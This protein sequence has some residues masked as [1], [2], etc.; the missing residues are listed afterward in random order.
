MSLAREIAQYPGA[1][2]QLAKEAVL[3]AHNSTLDEGLSMERKNFYLCFTSRNSAEG[4]AAF[5]E[6]RKP[7][8][9]NE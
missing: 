4:M 2:I 6:K 5:L 9:Q 3:F 7:R 8:F 1:A